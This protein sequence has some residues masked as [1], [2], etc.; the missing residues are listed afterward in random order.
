MARTPR[1]PAPPAVQPQAARWLMLMPNLPGST[2]TK[3]VRVWRR[4]QNVGAVAVRPSV[5]VLPAREECMET[6][7]WIAREINEM[8]GQVSLCEGQFVDGVTDDDI[9]RKFVEARNADYAALGK[10]ARELAKT[11]KAKR[12][13]AGL[14]ALEAQCATLKQRLE[15]IV[16]MDFCHASGREGAEGLIGG[17]ER[18][19]AEKRGPTQAPQRLERSSRPRGATWVTRAGVHVDRIACAWLIQRFIDPGATLKF[20]PAK[21]YVPQKGELRFDMYEA[22]FT[23]VGDRC[24]FE[25]LLERMAIEDPALAAIAE[26]IHD[27]D[28]RDEKFGREETAGVRSQITGLCAKHRDDLERIAAATSVLEALYAFFSLRSRRGKRGAES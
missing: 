28:L 23:H 11:V 27:I 13:A 17:I 15:E 9:E 10:E 25:V 12:S 6:F 7:Q 24:S 22:E 4:L 14:E 3:R 26:I 1:A 21:G 8:G 18:G 19:L 5:Y 16:S 20:V 2:T